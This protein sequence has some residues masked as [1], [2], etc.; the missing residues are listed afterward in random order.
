M[1]FNFRTSVVPSETKAKN[2]FL[3][4]RSEKFSVYGRVYA[5]FSPRKL[6][7]GTLKGFNP[8]KIWNKVRII[9][10]NTLIWCLCLCLSEQ[11]TIRQLLSLKSVRRTK[12]LV[13][14]CYVAR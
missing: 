12:Q 5:L 14:T 7:V 3:I 1:R 2:K 13:Y 4:Y 6:G 11:R 10:P 8:L 9:V